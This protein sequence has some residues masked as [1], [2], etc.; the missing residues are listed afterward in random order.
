VSSKGVWRVRVELPDIIDQYLILAR[1]PNP[2][3]AEEIAA[4]F[5]ESGGVTDEGETLRGREAIRQWW[6]GPATKYQYSVEVRDGHELGNGRY[7]VFTRLV[8]DFPGGVADLA[9]RFT[10][11]QG[12]ISQL[13][14]ASAEPPGA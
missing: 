9:N 7:V 5:S 12:L 13:E 4:C 10:L 14:I 6:R 1:T 3:D 11:S 2:S 8:G